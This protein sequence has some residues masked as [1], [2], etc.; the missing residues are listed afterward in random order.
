MR[1]FVHSLLRAAP[2]SLVFPA[3]ALCAALAGCTNLQ[4]PATDSV[5]VYL[6]DAQPAVPKA[7]ALRRN[8][9]LAVSPMRAR[10]GFENRGNRLRH[11]AVRA[12]LLLEKPL[13]RCA[14]EDACAADCPRS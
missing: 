14:G 12:R 7:A 9:V 1:P 13:G 6:L 10:P 5:N 8:E 4:A 3:I 2:G 11:A